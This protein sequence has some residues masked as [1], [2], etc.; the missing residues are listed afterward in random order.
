MVFEGIDAVSL[1]RK[2]VGATNPKDAMP[3]TIRGDY[4]HI[5]RDYVNANKARLPNIA[6]ASADATEAEKEIALWFK[7]SEIHTH[8]Q[9]GT[10]YKRGH[11]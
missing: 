10:L 9:E 5:S 2:L 8:E 4:S 1:V 7:D 3:G 11:K 6:H